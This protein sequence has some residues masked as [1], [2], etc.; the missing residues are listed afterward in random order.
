MVA[1]PKTNQPHGSAAV[2]RLRHRPLRFRIGIGRVSAAR[3][4]APQSKPYTFWTGP[5][6]G[7]NVCVVNWW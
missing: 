5:V 4:G 6:G 3:S 2:C 7:L 1:Q